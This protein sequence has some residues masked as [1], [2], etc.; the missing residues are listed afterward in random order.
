MQLKQSKNVSAL[1]AAASCALLGT[2]VQAEDNAEEWKFDTAILYYGE[3]DRVQLVEGVFNANKDFG[4][5]HYFNGKLVID[6]LT[7]ASASGAVAQSGVQTFTRPSGNDSYT[8]EGGET[9]LDDTFRDTRVQASGQWT[10]PLGE[11][12]RVSGGLQVSKEYDYL[13][14]VGNGS[15]DMDLNQRNTTLSAGMSYA[16][17]SIDPV[18]GRPVDFASMVVDNGQ[19]DSA[20]AYQQAF[21]ATRI[22]GSEEKDTIDLLFGVTQVINRRMLM[23]FNYSLS[24]SDGYHNDPYKVLSIVDQQG[25]T[26]DIVHESR[27]TERTKHSVYWQTKYALDQGVLDFSYRFATDDWEID[28]HTIDTRFRYN[29]SETSYIQPHIRYYQQNEAEFYNPFLS[30]A[31]PLPEHASA[32]YRLGKMTAITLGLKYGMQLENGNELAFR[33]EYYQQTP[34]NAGFEQPGSLAD[35]DLYPALKAVIAQVS[36]SF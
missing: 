15:L 31:T 13:S 21:D 1:L 2:S 16:F 5:E 6:T 3:T 18:G 33:L 19:F 32:D 14:I 36:Y 34:E 28:S 22:Q 30:Q 17:D 9:P 11:N 23:Q 4:N 29:L 26:Q 20:E 7:G 10:Q 24:M 27:P 25:V 12:Y 35:E 8:V